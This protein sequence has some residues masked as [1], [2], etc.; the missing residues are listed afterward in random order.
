LVFSKGA[1][2]IGQRVNAPM[3]IGQIL[4]QI[5]EANL[6][7]KV[8][9]DFTNFTFNLLMAKEAMVGKR[10]KNRAAWFKK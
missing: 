5:S 8:K 1:P 2:I 10:L 9:A 7:F 4:E 3:A 6:V